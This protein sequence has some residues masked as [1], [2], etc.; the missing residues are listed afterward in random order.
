MEKMRLRDF[1][2]GADAV[3]LTTYRIERNR[4][5]LVVFQEAALFGLVGAIVYIGVAIFKVD[6]AVTVALLFLLY[7]LAPR[8]S[9]LNNLRQTLGVAMASLRNVDATVL[10]SQATRITSGPRTF[11]R[12]TD[13]I[14]VKNVSFSHAGGP[15]VLKD[16][17]LV[18]AGNKLTALVGASGAGKSTLID[19]I[20]RFYDPNDGTIQSDG[21]DLGQLDLESWRSSIGLVSQDLFLFND[22]IANNILA[23][24]PSASEERVIEAAKQAHAH[25]FI[26]SLQYGYD[27][28]IGDRGWNLSG[29][30]RQRIALARAILKNPTVLSLDEATS[31]LDSE[32]ERFIQQ[33]I[34][35][36]RGDCTILVVAHRL[37]TIK[38]ADH[39]LVLQ[40]GQI[41]EEGDWDTLLSKTGVF[42]G[43][44]AIQ[45]GK[46]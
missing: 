19:L 39:I 29:G 33:Y 40:D 26:V 27:T 10:E 14:N 22:T 34:D 31:A 18:I 37:S 23:G 32:S 24:F 9:S 5:Q 6:L 1:Y 7:R 11:V 16:V 36:I 41:V 46:S 35:S 42:A 12:L 17:D 20:L 2:E 44:Y 43:L 21:V 25:D 45:V 8:V 13:S 4:S 3:R 38:Y 28:K 30:Q 15:Q